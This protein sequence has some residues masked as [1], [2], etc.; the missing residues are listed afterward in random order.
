MNLDPEAPLLST[1]RAEADLSETHIIS[2]R[3]YR[4]LT[5]N[6]YRRFKQMEGQ[7]IALGAPATVDLTSRLAQALDLCPTKA[8][9]CA[10]PATPPS[11][12]VD[13]SNEIDYK[14]LTDTSNGPAE[15]HAR[16]FI[17]HGRKSN[18]PGSH[19]NRGD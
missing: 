2:W 6:S 18:R 10:L 16:D 3:D 13:R 12:S 7:V 4:I 17:R 14:Y 15:P 19:S 8:D 5:L 1:L 9:V 11:D